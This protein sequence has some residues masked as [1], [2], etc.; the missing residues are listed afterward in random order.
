MPK[1]RGR[2]SKSG[3]VC[4][5]LAASARLTDAGGAA[6]FFFVFTTFF[7]G[8]FGSAFC[9]PMFRWNWVGRYLKEAV[10]NT[11]FVHY[12][13]KITTSLHHCKNITPLLRVCSRKLPSM[14]S[15]DIGRLPLFSGNRAYVRS[16]LL[17]YLM[18]VSMM[19]PDT[20][21]SLHLR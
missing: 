21:I 20:V 9:Q 18:A 16:A 12:P 7:V 17:L 3:L 8:I 19:A 11:L 13:G 6:T 10:V 15:A 5:F 1:L 4:F 14:E 2:F